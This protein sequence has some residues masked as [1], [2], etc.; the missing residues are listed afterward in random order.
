[1][2]S[3]SFYAVGISSEMPNGG[4][5]SAVFGSSGGVAAVFGSSGGVSSNALTCIFCV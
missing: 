2:H 1:M 3:E 4:N 5:C